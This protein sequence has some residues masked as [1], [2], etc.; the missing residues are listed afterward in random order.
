MTAYLY[1]PEQFKEE[2]DL[3][4]KVKGFKFFVISSNL[5]GTAYAPSQKNPCYR[6]PAAIPD[7]FADGKMNLSK[8]TMGFYFIGVPD[9][10]VL[11]EEARKQCEEDMRKNEEEVV[12]YLKSI[13][14]ATPEVKN[15]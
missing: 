4:V 6:I 14:N 11:N 15:K 10:D 9:I 3:L 5:S 2:I 1:T 13:G 12:H 7:V 8:A